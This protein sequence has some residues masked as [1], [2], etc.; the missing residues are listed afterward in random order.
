LSRPSA[1]L[2]PAVTPLFSKTD[3][4]DGESLK[5]IRGKKIIAANV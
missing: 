3:D 2:G 1:V 5:V 4:S